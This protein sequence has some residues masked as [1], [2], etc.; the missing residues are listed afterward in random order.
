MKRGK[1][2]ETESQK[3]TETDRYGYRETETKNEVLLK[4]LKYEG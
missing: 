4:I 3:M 2:G 1:K